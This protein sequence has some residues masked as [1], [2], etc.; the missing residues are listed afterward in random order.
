M[1]EQIQEVLSGKVALKSRYISASPKVVIV[2]VPNFNRKLIL[3][4]CSGLLLQRFFF[5]FFF[6]VFDEL[7]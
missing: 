3:I 1:S 2:S 7:N 5:C 6:F 4:P